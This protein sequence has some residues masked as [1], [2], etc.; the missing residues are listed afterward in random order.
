MLALHVL[1]VLSLSSGVAYHVAA[2]LVFIAPGSQTVT[3]RS[4]AQ[5][6]TFTRRQPEGEYLLSAT[7]V[8]S[9]GGWLTVFDVPTPIVAGSAAWDLR[10]TAVAVTRND[11][12]T[13]CVNFTRGA[14]AGAGAGAGGTRD[15]FW[16]GVCLD[17]AGFVEFDANVR[18]SNATAIGPV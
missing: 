2:S 10:P 5:T 18:V 1:L 13:A 9:P 12:A 6:V 17:S 8:L 3:L 11:G 16:I 7:Q 4:S 15:S 14:G